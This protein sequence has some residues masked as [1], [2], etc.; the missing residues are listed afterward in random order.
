MAHWVWNRKTRKISCYNG[1]DGYTAIAKP[2][3]ERACRSML[4]YAQLG[5]DFEDFMGKLDVWGIDY[6]RAIEELKELV[7]G[8]IVQTTGEEVFCPEIRDSRDLG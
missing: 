1:H 6:D 3:V 8:A 4:R 2:I 5:E 7:H